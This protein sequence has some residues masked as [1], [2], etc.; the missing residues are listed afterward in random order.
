M[1]SL[2]LL[3]FL[4]L[5]APAQAPLDAAACKNLPLTHAEEDERDRAGRALYFQCDRAVLQDAALAAKLVEHVHK[6]TTSAGSVV[7][8]GYLPPRV[9]EKEVA[10]QMKS[11]HRMKLNSW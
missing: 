3:A 4:P 11:S 10:R 6:G 8:L 1:T 9:A 7:L 2:F 5:L